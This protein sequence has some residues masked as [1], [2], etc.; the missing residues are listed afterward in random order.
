MQNIMQTIMAGVVV[1]LIAAGGVNVLWT[2]H[3]L[4]TAVTQRNTTV[5]QMLQSL[6]A[7]DA[8]T[9]DRLATLERRMQALD[10]GRQ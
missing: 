9:A 10:G 5:D 8:R 7:A 1:M 2:L 3:D 6:T 4:S